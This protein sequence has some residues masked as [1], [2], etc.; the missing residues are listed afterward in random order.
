M[1]L[2]LPI[3]IKRINNELEACSKYLKMEIPRIPLDFNEFPLQVNIALKNIPGYVLNDDGDVVQ[4]NDHQ[5]VLILS[6]EYGYR[7]PD[8]RWKT[9]IFH[10]NIM[11]PDEGGYVCVRTVD[12]WKFGSQLLSFIKSLEQLVSS[13]NPNS[14]FGSESCMKAS[15]YFIENSSKIEITLSYG[16]K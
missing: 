7:R 6:E 14:P 3:L 9:P 4:M 13:P 12:D 10:P 5:C 16:D 2:P 15:R 11:M 1:G 8:V